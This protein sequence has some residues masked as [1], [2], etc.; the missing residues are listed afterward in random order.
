MRLVLILIVVIFVVLGA[1]F[2]A[3]NA[4]RITID[5]YFAQVAVPKG[6]SLLG[7]IVVG[8]LL[9]GLVAWAS[10]DRRVRRDLRETRKQL[11][12]AQLQP[13]SDAR[14]DA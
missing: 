13:P 10:R 9:G 4:E 12:Q 14:P 3:L 8:W 6:A 11:K 2:G 7:A 5:L 1:V